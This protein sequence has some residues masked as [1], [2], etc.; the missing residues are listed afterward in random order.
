MAHINS[1]EIFGLNGRKK[2]VREELDRSINVLFGF[3]GS[4]KTSILKIIDS[5][6]ND[7]ISTIGKTFFESAKVSMHSIMYKKDFLMSYA[8]PKIAIRSQSLITGNTETEELLPYLDVQNKEK[9]SPGWK[10]SPDRIKEH[11]RWS[12]IYL[13]TTRLYMDDLT[14]VASMMM[15]SNQTQRGSRFSM[16]EN[17]DQ[18]FADALQRLWTAKYNR[19][20]EQVGDIQNDTLQN[21]FFDV[22]SPETV[23]NTG[24]ALSESPRADELGIDKAYERMSS[25]LSRQAENSGQRRLGLD[26][27]FAE[28]YNSDIRLRQVVRQIDIGEARIEAQW[29]PVEQL[30]KLVKTLFSGEKDMSFNGPKITVTVPGEGDIGLEQLSSGE[31]HLIRILLAAVDAGEST[32]LIDEPEMSLHIDWQRDLIS[33]LRL[34]NPNCQIIVATHSPEIMADVSDEMIFRV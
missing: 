7:D 4:G 16:D 1:F 2:V 28:R 21:I 10:W 6:M 11:R 23:T 32:I 18:A 29:R 3:N 24:N 33:N 15:L 30:T 9:K 17:L 27:S 25:F 20:V 22:L 26:Q 34:L 5:A 19:I 8:K 12:H 14:R 31:K 13:P